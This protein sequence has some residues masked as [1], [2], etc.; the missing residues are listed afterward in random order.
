M[1]RTIQ[2]E[3]YI[4]IDLEGPS[5]H[6]AQLETS[7]DPALKA[8]PIREIGACSVWNTA[9]K[10][11]IDFTKVDVTAGMRRFVAW[12]EQ[13][14]KPIAVTWNSWDYVW[15][16]H[17]LYKYIGFSPFG[18]PGRHVEIKSYYAGKMHKPYDETN[19][20][21]VTKIFP[22]IQKHAHVGVLDAVEQAEIFR[23]MLE[24]EL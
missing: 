19:K 12:L 24:L 4:S 18:V 3:D 9:N 23:Q 1:T 14:R 22:S 13:F 10:I 5:A 11:S 15:V 6:P 7:P 21:Q 20:R 2:Q 8:R 17:Y 16:Q